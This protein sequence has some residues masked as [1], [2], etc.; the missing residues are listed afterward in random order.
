MFNRTLSDRGIYLGNHLSKHGELTDSDVYY[1]GRNHLITIGTTGCGKGTGLIIP[2]LAN[3]LPRSILIIDPKGEAAAI[4]AKKRKKLGDVF[5]LNPFG[6]LADQYPHLKS[7]GYNPLIPLVKKLA[8][9]KDKYEQFPDDAM[10]I[11]EALVKVEEKDRHWSAS[12]QD[13]IAA[14]V[15]WECI[16]SIEERRT[17]TL[18]NV[19][20]MLTAAP[21]Y[22]K[23]E[24]GKYTKLTGGFPFTVDQMA[25]CGYEPVENKA[26]RFTAAT[27]E[28]HSIMSTAATQT[29]FLDSIPI[30]TDLASGEFD[31]AEMKQRIITVYLILPAL[32]LETHGNWLRLIVSSALK[33]L[34]TTP[35]KSPVLFMLDEFAQLGRL[36]TIASAMS[37]ARGYGIQ[38]WPFLQDL[39]QLKDIYGEHGY[40]TFIS[41]RE[42]LT[43]FPPK[44]LTTAKYF[45]ELFGQRTVE[46]ES[47]TISGDGEGG[48]RGS[49]NT[50]IQDFPLIRP[51][52]LM[53]MRERHM[54]CIV[55]PINQPIRALAKN[56]DDAD[57]S[58]NT[59]RAGLDKN[60]YHH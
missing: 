35:G 18:S 6:E 44:D 59:E 42:A 49:I 31:F 11:A 43:L 57:S 8:A 50:S 30:A 58:F 48:V 26:G 17:P 23:D 60:P 7:H 40:E 15:M 51:Q 28:M 13:L 9:L 3:D 36:S 45:S 2:N 55:A 38:L 14:L 1:K 33:A 37:I 5:I 53:S 21:Q 22:E 12:A 10:L 56:Y 41:Q 27:N 4:T 32:R 24:N 47:H 25:S 29:R 20:K 16:K 52:A 19:R 46:R 34:L 39:N 54:I